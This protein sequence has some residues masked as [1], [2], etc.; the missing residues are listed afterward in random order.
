MTLYLK[1]YNTSI[2]SFEKTKEVLINP[3]SGKLVRLMKFEPDGLSI[4]VQFYQSHMPGLYL[5]YLKLLTMLPIKPL[6]YVGKF[7]IRISNWTYYHD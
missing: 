2:H 3:Q 7:P 6:A 5:K 4:D 1:K